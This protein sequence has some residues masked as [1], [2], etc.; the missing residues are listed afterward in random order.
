MTDG[1]VFIQL[2]TKKLIVHC[3]NVLD[4]LQMFINDYDKP[5]LEALSY[6]TGQCNYGGR[7]TDDLDRRLITSLLEIF[8]NEKIIFDDSYRFSPGGLY[9]APPKG[10]YDDYVDYIRRLPLIPHPEV[11]V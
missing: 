8:Y 2:R 10:S 7:V 3:D 5:P 1:G 9:Y 11:K 6:L 4:L